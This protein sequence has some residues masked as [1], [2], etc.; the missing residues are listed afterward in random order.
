MIA[1]ARPYLALLVCPLGL[2]VAFLL[3][4]AVLLSSGTSL[5]MV[6]RTLM[7]APTVP[8]ILGFGSA[9]VVVRWMAGLDG[10]S[11]AQLGWSRP[12]PLDASIAVAGIA[13][14]VPLHLVAIF[15]ALAELD[16][17]FDPQLEGLS[18]PAA[19]AG[20]LVSVVVE[21]TVYRGYALDL[22]HARLGR[23]FAVLL[24]S[25]GY[26]LLVPGTGLALKAWAVAFG[27]LLAALKS[28]RGSLWPGALIHLALS[29]GPKIVAL[30]QR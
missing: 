13:V 27:L 7:R 15:P 18:L 26:A 28:W 29:L 1:R 3:S 19:L 21:E 23:F 8:L 25:F 16:P 11:L 6:E 2:G 30:V 4:G 20:F 17:S 5:S 14:L 22:L 24:T 10:R 12:S 9:F